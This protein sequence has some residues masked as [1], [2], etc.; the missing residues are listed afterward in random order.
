VTSSQPIVTP[1]AINFTP[2]NLRCYAYSGAYPADGASHVALSFETNS[3]YIVAEIKV[4]GAMNP[5]TSSVAGTN[6]QIKFNGT[7]IGAGPMSTALDKPYY[8]FEK[9]VIPPFTA[10][11]VLINFHETDSNDIATAVLQGKVYGMTDTGFQ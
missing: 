1:N 5:L 11:Q 3:E 9:L 6:G 8:Y 4:N 7:T 2:D 10:V